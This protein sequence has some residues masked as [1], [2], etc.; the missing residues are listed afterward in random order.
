MANDPA[1]DEDLERAAEEVASHAE[2]RALGAL[3]FEVLSRQAEGRVLF[4]G[5]EFVEARAREHGVDRARAGTSAGNLLD[6]L[7]RG[8]GTPRERALVAAFGVAGLG[9]ALGAAREPESLLV[10]F[11]RHADWLDTAS[12]YAVYPLVDRLLAGPLGAAVWRTVAERTIAEARAGETTPAARARQ[13][14]RLAALAGSS[15]AQ[16]ELLRVASEAP[17]RVVRAFAEALARGPA[18]STAG[19]LAAGPARVRG[20]VGRARGGPLREGLRWVSGW[21]LAAWCARALL[22]LAAHRRDAELELGE[23]GVRVRRSTRLFGRV[24]RESA[25]TWRWAALGGAAREV[26]YP[27]LGLV[28]GA[29]GLSA[30]VLVG[31]LLGFDG[32]RAGEPSLLALGALLVLAGAGLDLA[33]DVLLAGRRGR[34]AFMLRT[35]PTGALRVEGVDPE[36]AERFLAALES[37]LPR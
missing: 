33:L 14:A 7:E 17:D 10:R 23:Q 24:V 12:P 29:V 2:R 34:V 16:A 18:P 30:G 27:R 28:V 1:R 35:L 13:A 26:R 9:A 36:D 19:G 15:A 5:R 3:C 6:V 25:E 11:V 21:A 22:A 20:R 8:P 37:A 4:T 31:G 32:L